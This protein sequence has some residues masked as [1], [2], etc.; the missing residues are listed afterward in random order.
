MWAESWM[1]RRNQ[2]C[3]DLGRASKNRRWILGLAYSRR[4][5]KSTGA[6]AQQ[7]KSGREVAWNESGRKAE[8]WAGKARR[9]RILSALGRCRSFKLQSIEIIQLNVHTCCVLCTIH[10]YFLIGIIFLIS[11]FVTSFNIVKFFRTIILK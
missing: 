8:A 2:P 1:V 7:V 10:F 9:T 3:K 6:G 5:N 11:N 4:R